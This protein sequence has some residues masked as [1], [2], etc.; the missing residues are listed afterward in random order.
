MAA[1]IRVARG[2][3]SSKGAL[4]YGEIFWQKTGT[5]EEG[6]LFIGNPNGAGAPDLKIAGARAMKSLYYQGQH[7][8]AAFPENAKP[9]DYWVMTSDGTGSIVDYRKN[10][11]VVC[12]SEGQFTRVNNSGG[13]STEVTFNNAGTNFDATTVDAALREL[14]AEKLQYVRTFMASNEVPADP[15]I[16]GF[17]LIGND[18]VSVG[19]TPYT[20]GDFAYF[21][22][23]E[24]VRIP[25]GFTNASDINFDNSSVTRPIGSPIITTTVQAALADI[26][27]N[28]ADLDGSG[29]VPTSQLPD[30]V[31]G[32]L[33]YKGTWDASSGVY[34]T[35]VQK[36]DYYVASSAGVIDGVDYETGDWTVFD[37]TEWSK[38][39]NSERLSGIVVNGNNL[40]GSPEIR[41]IDKVSVTASGNVITVAGQNLVD[42]SGT[43]TAGVIPKFTAD[44]TIG[45]SHISEDGQN[46]DIDANLIV[47]SEGTLTPKTVKFNGPLTIQPTGIGGEKT[48]HGIKL[49]SEQSG[50]A[51]KYAEVKAP[52]VLTNDVV[53]T[54]PNETSTI[55]G[56]KA[57]TTANKITKV[58]T[59]GFIK[60]SQITDDGTK[61]VVDAPLE[62]PQGFT[63]SDISITDSNG[64]KIT[65]DAP[66]LT[67]DRTLTLPSTTGTLATLADVQAAEGGSNAALEA[68]VDGT[69]NKVAIFT[70]DH[71]IGD[72]IIEQKADASGIEVAGTIQAKADMLIT[73]V[74]GTAT[75][76]FSAGSLIASVTQTIPSHSGTLLNDNSTV[77]G[78]EF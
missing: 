26:Y 29:K 6:T 44:G 9:G 60:D 3:K 7:S 11:W 50:G 28:K 72:S 66:N 17:Y 4:L 55:I 70:D 58:D 10:D 54:T 45:N 37:G 49:G 65:I 69:A 12:I 8:G 59:N 5:D 75:A 64:N 68:A 34:P 35:D 31:L 62:A 1:T 33:Y 15:V 18:G 16:G 73:S 52:T 2:N 39:D 51:I 38:V 61:V 74:N 36:G 71:A 32:A 24:W 27:A 42:K 57:P 43:T 20:K 25:S 41:G 21:N 63:A 67:G 19:G 56:Q 78:G 23:I 13:R 46:V 22:S 14:E 40:A 77:D 48:D 76:T 30:T 53:V 47:G